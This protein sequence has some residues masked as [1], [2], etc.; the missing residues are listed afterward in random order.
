M[1]GLPESLSPVR[2]PINS[3]LKKGIRAEE[4]L[5]EPST[6]GVIG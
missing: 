5:I 3:N 4:L 6:L 2:L 1:I